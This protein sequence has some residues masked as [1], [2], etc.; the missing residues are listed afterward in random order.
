[1]GLGFL[2]GTGWLQQWEG[3]RG[4]AGARCCCL[5]SHPLGPGLCSGGLLSPPPPGCTASPLA[6]GGRARSCLSQHFL[7]CGNV[8][9]AGG[10]RWSSGLST[11]QPPGA[12][13]SRALRPCACPGSDTPGWGEDPQGWGCSCELLRAQSQAGTRLV[14]PCVLINHGLNLSLLWVLLTRP[15]GGPLGGAGGHC[16]VGLSAGGAGAQAAA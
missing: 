4:S 11:P 5:P 7:E 12:G 2:R 16:T 13:L 6:V 3:Q 10:S 14:G 9:V 1:M 15:W 8:P